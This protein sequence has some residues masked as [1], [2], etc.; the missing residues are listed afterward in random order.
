MRQKEFFDERA[1]K[2][3]H[4][5]NHDPDKL[6]YIFNIINL[7][8]N[9]NVLDV[10]TGTGVL[11]PYIHKVIGEQGKITA[12]DLSD[13]ML[14]VAREKFSFKNVKYIQNDVN[15]L[16]I[17]KEYDAII[18]YSVFPH[19]ID[20]E[21]TIKHLSEGLKD[22]GKLV[23]CHS[24]SRDAIN[25]LHKKAG[26]EVKEDNL[27]TMDKIKEMFNKVNLKVQRIIDNDEM[28]LI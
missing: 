2:W 6:D 13:K 7:N 22:K 14:D 20:K 25:N 9:D 8:K 27:P 4:I 1:L 3:D 28:F 11:I 17:K 12:I 19:F 15:N 23:I 16:E 10:G 18:C 24:Q 5:V 26:E 21:V